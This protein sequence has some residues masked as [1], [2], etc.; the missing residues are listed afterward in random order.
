M[1]IWREGEWWQDG[2][3]VRWSVTTLKGKVGEREK[4]VRESHVEIVANQGKAV[5]VGAQRADGGKV[6][7]GASI[8]APRAQDAEVFDLWARANFQVNGPKTTVLA[9]LEGQGWKKVVKE[10]LRAGQ[11]ELHITATSENGAQ[12]QLWISPADGYMAR[13]ILF[14]R[15]SHEERKPYTELFV[16]EVQETAGP[17]RIKFPRKTALNIFLSGHPSR[18]PFI[19]TVTTFHSAEVDPEFPV[20]AFSSPTIPDGAQV[21]D[22]LRG[23]TF[24]AKQGGEE[25]G[26]VEA[27]TPPPPG[28]SMSPPESSWWPMIWWALSALALIGVSAWWWKMR[29]NRTEQ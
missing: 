26:T 23:V 1:A 18:K 8:H 16:E 6:H 7:V 10:G 11:K 15:G 24:K 12:V 3:K 14:S 28:H 5:G 27:L 22:R 25:P 13:R 20:G 29:V 17:R 19:Q 21:V 2:E 4:A 9:V